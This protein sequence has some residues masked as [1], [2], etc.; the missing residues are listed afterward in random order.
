MDAH[1]HM[2]MLQLP[3]NTNH[4]V[5]MLAQWLSPSFPVGAFAYSH[6]LETVIQSGRIASADAVQDWLVDVLE[7]GS[8]RNDCILLRAAY[9]CATIDQVEVVNRTAIAV[10]ASSER[11]LE[12][13]LEGAMP[14]GVK[15]STLI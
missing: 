10:S 1:I 2:N 4:D 13:T 8:G 12:T 9:A 6:G 15:S 7:F 3:M 14:H 11:V 5:L